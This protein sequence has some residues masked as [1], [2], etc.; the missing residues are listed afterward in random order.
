VGPKIAMGVLSA[1]PPRELA[2]ALEQRDIKRLNN[3][4]GVGK[5]TAERLVLELREKLP[6][7]ADLD[8]SGPTELAPKDDRARL[9]GALTNMGYKPAE[10]E[11]AVES[12]RERIGKDSLS[13][14]LRAALRELSP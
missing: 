5:K 12:V 6:Q 13:E 14:L 3:V 1:L 10:A 7:V 11:R 2:L 8:R 9:A 4:N